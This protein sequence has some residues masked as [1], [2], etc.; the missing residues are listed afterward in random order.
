M[1]GR[2]QTRGDWQGYLIEALKEDLN[3]REAEI[4]SI[5]NSLRYRVGGWVLEAW[6]PGPRTLVIIARML[7]A[8]VRL[9]SRNGGNTGATVTSSPSVA[10]AGRTVK[11]LIFGY[12][13]PEGYASDFNVCLDDPAALMVLLDSDLPA[14]T[15]VLRLSDQ[16]I[17]RRVERLR[18]NG[19]RV[20]W[21]P[22]GPCTVEESP[23]AQYLSAHA[24]ECRA[25]R[26]L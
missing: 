10:S 18:L 26:V 2:N 24:D 11:A 20:V 21:W 1:T 4:A 17:T 15:L 9:K 16:A 8:F 7:V 19:W 14:G 13:V 12:D 5:R 25:G 3:S 23:Q 6:P 22:E